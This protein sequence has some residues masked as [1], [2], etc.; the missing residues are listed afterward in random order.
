MM[1]VTR[2]FDFCDLIVANCVMAFFIKVI[3]LSTIPVKQYKR[4]ASAL[5]QKRVLILS[6]VIKFKVKQ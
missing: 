4:F 6:N 2:T 5:K 1:Q 3:S